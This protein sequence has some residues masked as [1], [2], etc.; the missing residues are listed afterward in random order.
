RRLLG[1]L[2]QRALELEH[3]QTVDLA[4]EIARQQARRLGPQRG[5][6]ARRT[7]PHAQSLAE[8]DDGRARDSDERRDGTVRVAVAEEPLLHVVERTVERGVVPVEAAAT[9]CRADAERDEDAAIRIDVHA[10]GRL[11]G[12]IAQRLLHVL[13]HTQAFGLAFDER[14]HERPVL[15]ERRRMLLERERELLAVEDGE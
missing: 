9:L 5:E 2:R 7:R 1:S 10:R 11:A 13:A 8:L 4:A 14:T 6:L 15:V 3:A 12:E